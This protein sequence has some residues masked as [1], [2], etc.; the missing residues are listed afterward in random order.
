MDL[1]DKLPIMLA[2]GNLMSET[3]EECWCAGWMENTENVLPA[4]CWMAF[5]TN[6]PQSWGKGVISVEWAKALLILAEQLGGWVTLDLDAPGE[7][8]ERYKPHT[9]DWGRMIAMLGD[10]AATRPEV[11]TD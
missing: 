3:S 6:K 7:Y 9:P 1:Q 4:L 8:Y 10:D 5:V 2:L 11:T